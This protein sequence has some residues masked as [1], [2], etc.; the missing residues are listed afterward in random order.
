MAIQD[1]PEHAPQHRRQVVQLRSP[2]HGVCRGLGPVAGIAGAIYVHNWE[3]TL[4]GIML[5]LLVVSGVVGWVLPDLI[6]G[7][8][9]LA[10]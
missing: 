1:A 9:R 4:P 10:G 7:P 6:V 5:A 2:L 8:R 3:W